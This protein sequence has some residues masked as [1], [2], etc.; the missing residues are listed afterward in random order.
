[1]TNPGRVPK[2]APWIMGLV[3]VWCLA[4]LGYAQLPKSDGPPAA[5]DPEAVFKGLDKV[6][7]TSD[8]KPSLF[9]LYIDRKKAQVLAEL[10]RDF[11]KKKY[12]IALTVAGGELYAGLQAGDLYVYWKKYDNRLALIE[13]D[14]GTRST[15]DAESKSAVG[16]LFTGR[17]IADVPILTKTLRD[18]QVLDIVEPRQMHE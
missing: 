10:P 1:M 14:L 2:L 8:G 6:I 7:S 5:K 12:F 18:W 3:G 13:P 17:V 15:G 16:R 11:E 4:Q 9:T